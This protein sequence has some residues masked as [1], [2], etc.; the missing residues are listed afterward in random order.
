MSSTALK[1]IAAILML[2]DHIGEFMPGSPIWFRWLGRLSAPLFMFCLAHSFGHTHDRR[3]MLKRL[4]LCGVFMGLVDLIGNF[5]VKDPG[6]PLINNIFVTYFLCGICVDLIEQ[7][8]NDRKKGLK[9]IAIFVAYQFFA[10]L[11]I[12][13]ISRFLSLSYAQ[14]LGVKVFLGAALSSCI[15]SE[16]GIEFIILGVALYCLRTDK[17]KMILCFE[18]FSFLYLLMAVSHS[19][20]SLNLINKNFQWMMAGSVFLMAAYNGKRG[21]GA[22]S[23]FYIFYPVHIIILFLLGNICR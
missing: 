11:V 19:G 1:M 16:G 23:F 17:K 5:A 14:D 2:I 7:L 15:F 13:R 9:N 21:I 22:K 6:V 10:A 4:Y 20:I 18:W 8:Q 12:M 3:A